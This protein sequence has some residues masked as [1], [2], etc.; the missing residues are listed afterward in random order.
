MFD[1]CLTLDLRPKTA[2]DSEQEGSEDNED[3][4]T[5]PEARNK[6]PPRKLKKDKVMSS[7]PHRTGRGPGRP[8]KHQHQ[9]KDPQGQPQ[10]STME[11]SSSTSA[12]PDFHSIKVGRVC[13]VDQ[14]LV[15]SQV[16]RSQ[17]D[18]C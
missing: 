11:T 12:K 5:Y 9:H 15:S 16:I 4:W 8:P 18:Q 7:S 10:Q 17:L 2:L 1:L 3:E 14:S 6:G 13:N